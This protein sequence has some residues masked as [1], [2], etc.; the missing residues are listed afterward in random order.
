MSAAPPDNADIVGFLKRQAALMEL[1]GQNSF[2]VRAFDNAARMLEELEVDIVEMSAAETLTEIDGIGKGLAEFVAEYIESGS[3]SAYDELTE[4][5]PET[6]LDILRI[7]GLGTKKVKAI[8]EALDIASME[9][10]EAACHEGQLD[11]LSGFGKKTQ[12]NI[13]KGIAG[14]SRYQGQYRLDQAL[15]DA[16]ALVGQL[17]SHPATI[18]V[19]IAGSLRRHKEVVKDVDIVLSTES[20]VD[21]AE[22]FAALPQVI[23]VLSQ[24]ERKTAVRLKSG[25]QV[26]LRLV[27][28][29]HYASMLHHFTGS[30]DHNVTMRSRALAR[31]LHLNEYGL[32]RGKD[33][34][35]DRIDTADEDELFHALELNFVPPELREGLGEVEAAEEGEL[36][37]LLQASDIRGMLHVHTKASDG[38]DTLEETVAAVRN[39]GY[40]Y[41]AICDHSKSAGYVFGLKVADIEEQHAEIDALQADSPDFRILKGI[42]SDILRNG[43]LDYDD[44]VLARFDLVVVA[45]HNAL[46]MDES[47]LTARVI[48]AIEHPA[49]SV[50]AHPTGRLLLERDGYRIN[51]E[52]VVAAA[53][54]N[55]VA[56]ELN[57]HPARFDLDWRWLNRAK[58]AG[59]KVAVN[60]DAHRISDLDSLELGTGIARK[61][62]L[63]PD[64]VINTMTVDELLAWVRG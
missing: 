7:P 45:I 42:E 13:L 37:Q 29:E 48:K 1:A 16:R 18:R 6:L 11:G 14:L 12:E 59:C 25:I 19:S 9:E 41:V 44:D 47:A 60:T 4:T 2:R 15:T 52:E 55:N 20:P 36:P 5:V 30:K 28:D 51:L 33:G 31:D 53:A 32:F 35:G 43:D 50:L 40:E 39:R 27:A 21:V 46:A 22:A 26:D 34:G 64:D 10:L 3:T 61:G 63:T 24:G 54:S 58:E 57:T 17:E 38:D 49:A 23:D 8:H 56:L 62:W